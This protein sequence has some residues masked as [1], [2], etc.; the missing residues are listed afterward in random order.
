M[1]SFIEQVLSLLTTTP[2]NLAYHLVLAFTIAATFQISLPQ[3]KRSN[4]PQSRRLVVG[5]AILLFVRLLLFLASIF[6]WQSISQI[7][8]TH[9][10]LL[11]RSIT[12]LSLLIIIWLWTF[13]DPTPAAD[14]AFAFLGALT[15]LFLILSLL[16]WPNGN[17][18][19][20]FNSSSADVLWQTFTI[21]LIFLAG[22]LLVVRLPLGW[23]IGLVF[24]TI[25]FFGHLVHLV[26]PAADANYPGIVRLAQLAAYP[27]LF[28][29]PQRFPIPF[30]KRQVTYLPEDYAQP[31]TLIDEKIAHS[32]RDLA[33]QNNPAQV[34]PAL[35]H[36][37]AHL[38]SSDIC[39]LLATNP[40]DRRV[41]IQFG[42]DFIRQE[43]IPE[44][45]FEYS[46]LP[47]LANALIEEKP[48]RLADNESITDQVSLG[49]ALDLATSGPIISVPLLDCSGKSHLSLLLLSPYSDRQWD[50]DDEGF[51]TNLTASFAPTLLRTRQFQE[52]ENQ[53][54]QLKQAVS[55]AETRVNETSHLNET[56]LAKLG[57]LQ[58][59]VSQ[60]QSRTESLAALIST[61][62]STPDEN[63]DAPSEFKLD[64]ASSP[65][66]TK[67]DHADNGSQALQENLRLAQEEIAKLKSNLSAARDHIL[68]VEES[69]TTSDDKDGRNKAI[70]SITQ[71]LRLPLSSIIGYTEVLLNSASASLANPQ[72]KVLERIKISTQRLAGLLEDLAQLTVT[73]DPAAISQPISL[74][75][76]I[77]ESIAL[78]HQ[79][80]RR[81]KLTIKTDIPE[82]LPR[83]LADCHLLRQLILF[84]INQVTKN[85]PPGE[86]I[87]FLVRDSGPE[88]P[89]DTILLQISDSGPG[90]PP[91]ELSQ[92]FASTEL[93]SQAS[94][95]D[96]AQL[97][98]S[99]L[100]SQFE[101][102]GGK[103]WVDSV[104]GQ[105]TTFGLLL[106]VYLPTHLAFSPPSKSNEGFK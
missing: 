7:P 55:A 43:N 48:L 93:P 106:P 98:I 65:E 92:V 90:I 25:M 40:P 64:L 84:I 83:I 30:S 95:D 14:K 22:I 29:L 86:S 91:I 19:I 41:K 88:I 59:N 77:E 82:K 23:G 13:P 69:Q 34:Y 49:N 8:E 103:V 9:F 87:S 24:M 3:I 74:L 73:Q 60:E 16:W 5:L 44:I 26:S 97:P 10:A 81:K 11:D 35:A 4:S 80:I 1:A 70:I 67:A 12:A 31:Q 62:Y 102:Q 101:S 18:L 15:I 72:R 36:T 71:E 85:T 54:D 78:S 37:I 42:Y 76:L 63:K 6:A 66:S 56:L 61:H 39:L 68:A 89:P 94:S 47:V 51:L 100:K 21:F 99:A 38:M 57:A 53:I 79:G 105:G 45:A 27:L 104:E 58:E 75:A 52:M 20:P 17:Q 2:G 32:I 33:T 96:L 46:Q 28:F 50:D